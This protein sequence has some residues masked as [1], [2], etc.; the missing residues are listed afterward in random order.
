MAQTFDLS[1]SVNKKIIR[2]HA[3]IVIAVCAIFGV[4]KNHI[5]NISQ[6]IFYNTNTAN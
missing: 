4:I 2:V 6:V 5:D 1:G 3:I